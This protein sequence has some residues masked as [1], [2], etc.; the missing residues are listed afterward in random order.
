MRHIISGRASA[1][2]AF[3]A[4]LIVALSLL[5]GVPAA[6]AQPVE[7]PAAPGGLRVLDRPEDAGKRIGLTWEADPVDYAYQV[8]RSEAPE[9]PYE[10]V[11]GKAS[12]SMLD[13]PVF[14][15]DTA[16]AGVTYY[17]KVTSI[18]DYWLEGPAC[19]PVSAV[20]QA[21]FN[22][23]TGA[24][25]ILIS[26][27]DQ[28]VYYYEGNQ[29]INIL[30]CSTGARPG[31]TPT[32]NFRILHHIRFNAGCDYWLSFTAGHGMH[33]WPRNIPRYEEGLGAPASHG[34]VR[35]HPLEAY[36]P[37]GWAPDGT[38]IHITYASYA[39]RLVNGCSSTIGSTQLSNDW[40]FAEGC[41]ADTF[42]TWLLLAN[43]G[44]ADA[45]VHVD[46]LLEGGAAVPQDY[47][48][49]AHT[50]FSLPVD[51][52]PG[53]EQVSC[54]MNVHSSQPIVAERA[55]YFI[56]DNSKSDGSVTTGAVAPSSDWYFAEGYCAGDFDSYLLLANP[57]NT[58]VT[59]QLDFLL[60]GGAT[61]HQ[62]Y[63]VAPRS[64]FSV[65]VD[66]IPGMEE[67]A[68]STHVYASGPD[69]GRAGHVLPQ[70]LRGRGA[71][72][73]GGD[74]ALIPVVLRRGLHP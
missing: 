65:P 51:D 74:P 1:G 23:A 73:H 17:Y 61:L 7:G 13:Y 20:L 71:R 56:F 27:T 34:C 32:G 43:P 46:F 8:Y 67:A 9:G 19:E 45:S 2:F 39:R 29:L 31:S 72:V 70:G 12:D 5:P 66:G 42:D 50:R 57:G 16:A 41:T 40:F 59:A 18:D 28:K 53:L 36:W 4:V 35:V 37:Y 44:S 49:A 69:R 60:E 55:M 30:R 14:M 6:P 11:G 24:K 62:E 15:D 68:F 26:I 63:P 10:V 52:L 64:R 3:A 48:V 25:S 58:A 38:P 54:S 22:A 47:F 33:G 21:G